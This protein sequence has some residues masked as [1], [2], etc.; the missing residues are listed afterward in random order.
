MYHGTWPIEKHPKMPLGSIHDCLVTTSKHEETLVNEM[1]DLI[2]QVT[3][4]E[5][6]IKPEYWI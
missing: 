5:P 4:I 3:T 6:D 1:K 2:K